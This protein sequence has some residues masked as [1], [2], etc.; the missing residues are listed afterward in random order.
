[1]GCDSEAIVKLE[2]GEMIQTNLSLINLTTGNQASPKLNL[3]LEFLVCWSSVDLEMLKEISSV[4]NVLHSLK[5]RSRNVEV[6]TSFL[7]F[8]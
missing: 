8:N 3:L 6:M 1:M 4:T 2:E 7:A 5:I